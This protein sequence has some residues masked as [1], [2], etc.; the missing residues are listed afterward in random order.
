MLTRSLPTHRVPLSRAFVW[1]PTNKPAT[2]SK[3][4]HVSMVKTVLRARFGSF[5]RTWV[6]VVGRNWL[7]GGTTGPTCRSMAPPIRPAAV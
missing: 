6:G 4:T 2:V 1:M 7:R 3:R 5:T